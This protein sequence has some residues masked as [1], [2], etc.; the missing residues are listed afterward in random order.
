M[1]FD[2]ALD[3]AGGVLRPD[4]SAPGH[5]LRFKERDAARYRA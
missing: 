3:P 5:G 4:L 1:L 2:G